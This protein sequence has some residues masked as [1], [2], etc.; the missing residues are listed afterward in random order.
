MRSDFL[1]VPN[2]LYGGDAGNGNG[3]PCKAEL[4]DQC[5]DHALPVGRPVGDRMSA[6]TTSYAG[7]GPKLNRGISSRP[8]EYGCPHL[9]A[10]A[11]D[12]V[13]GYQPAVSMSFSMI[14]CCFASTL[15]HAVVRL[16]LARRRA[17]RPSARFCVVEASFNQKKRAAGSRPFFS[18]R[19]RPPSHQ[20]GRCYC[21]S[22]RKCELRPSSVRPIGP[23]V[24]IAAVDK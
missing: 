15:S 22:G 2:M 19:L 23:P 17:S 16:E 14:A 1:T 3:R 7:E 13:P 10:Y 8:H 12:A 21:A 24:S 4:R 11:R 20:A 18:G 5:L 6:R 9:R